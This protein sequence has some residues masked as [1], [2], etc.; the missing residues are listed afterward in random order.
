MPRNPNPHPLARAGQLAHLALYLEGLARCESDFLL[1]DA[2]ALVA[3][4]LAD[5]ARE[6]ALAIPAEAVPDDIVHEYSREFR[7]VRALFAHQPGPGWLEDN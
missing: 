5:Q 3:P 2:C 1:R 7:S 6:C 4:T